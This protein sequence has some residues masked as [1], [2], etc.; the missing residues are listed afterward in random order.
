MSALDVSIRAQILNLLRDL[1]AQLGL[2]YLF[3][4]HDLAAVA[5]M[6]HTIAVMYLGR[7]VEMGEAGELSR[8]PK[9]PYTKA[10]FSA[11]LPSHPDERREEII[12]PGEVPSPLRPPAGCR[13]HPRC[14]EAM[15]RCST[16]EPQLRPLEGRVVA[17]H[18]FTARAV[19]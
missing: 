8:A 17:C 11:A 7:L 19:N 12:L 2:S 1:Q 15:A 10:L 4:A 13:F 9:H 14:P 16:E 18:L 3:I 5:H 6:S